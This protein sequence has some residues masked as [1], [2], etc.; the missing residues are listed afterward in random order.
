[1]HVLRVRN[2]HE[3][4]PRGLNLLYQIGTHRES[5]NG[6]V[7]VAR[8]PVATVYERPWEKVV[9][10]PE[11]DA[12]PFFH[13][14]ESLW[15][16]AGRN[17][18]AF[19]RKYASNMLNYSDDGIT[20][21]DAYGYR[22]RKWF[23]KDQLEIVIERLKKNPDDRRCVLQLWDV[24]K[25]LGMDGKAFPCNTMITVQIND[26]GQLEIVVFCRSNDIVWGTFGANAVH[27]GFLQEYL[28]TR[29]GVQIGTYTQ[30]SINYHAYI[31]VLK[32][33]LEDIR[34]KGDRVNY[35][36]NPYD[37]FF[38]QRGQVRT[39]L[40]PSAIDQILDEL[41]I[42]EGTEFALPRT[43]RSFEDNAWTEMAYAMLRAHAVYRTLDNPLNYHSAIDILKTQDQSIDWIAAGIQWMQR[44]LDAWTAKSA[45][46]AALL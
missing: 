27:F 24:T 1:M 17:D 9:F 35:I 37:S 40:M 46:Q 23:D 19:V 3:G 4:L 8:M 30:V 29:I 14:A 45:T 32:D 33:K 12:N 39:V 43:Y 5:R 21:H 6:A 13:F 25:D 36:D 31:N 7:L 16:L 20:I 34:F 10:W 42:H 41:L 28:A 15:I 44:R 18:V 11:R 26:Q 38:Q 22:L 2:A